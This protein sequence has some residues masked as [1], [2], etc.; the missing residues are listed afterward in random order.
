L[1]EPETTATHISYRSYDAEL[2]VRADG[3]ARLDHRDRTWTARLEPV[4]WPRLL[5][6]LGG[7]ETG[8]GTAARG[9]DV[10]PGGGPTLN[11]RGAALAILEALVHQLGEGEV[12]ADPAGLP[13]V[14]H[15]RATNEVRPPE[16]EA[17]AAFG[18]VAGRAACVILTPDEG[19]E[20]IAMPDG[21][22]LGRSAGSRLPTRAVALGRDL[23]ATGGDDRALRVWDAAAGGELYVR[24][25]PDGPVRAVAT[26]AG[27][28]VVFAAGRDGRLW[29]W[30]CATGLELGAIPGWEGSFNAACSARVAGLDLVAAGGDDGVVRVWNIADGTSV[31]TL[32]GHTG[33]VN[34]VAMLGAGDQGLVASAGLDQVV[35]IW[36]LGT[37]AEVRTLTGHTGSV[38]ALAFVEVA[39]GRPV[40]AS[41]S[42]DGT[43]RVWDV[44]KGEP[45]CTWQT[46]DGWPTA[47]ATVK[48]DG[49]TLL[50]TTALDGTV[51]LWDAATGAPLR[52][53]I[54]GQ[55]A[56][57]AGSVTNPAGSVTNPAG[58]AAAAGSVA[59]T[60]VAGRPVIA[61]GHQ[62]GTV[63]MWNAA[64][65]TPL[66]T[67]ANLAGGVTSVAFGRVG[68]VPV[69]VC[70]TDQGAVRL[71]DALTGALTRVPTPH[72]GMITALAFPPADGGGFL[73]SGGADLTVRTWDALTGRPLLCLSPGLA[74]VTAVAA[75]RALLAAAAPDGVVGVWDLE[76]RPQHAA[77]PHS[78]QVT[79]LA[80]G[81][82]EG[83]ELLASG[84]AQGT[85]RVWDPITGERLVT[86]SLDGEAVRALA[87]APGRLAVG[88]TDGTVRVVSLPGG[89]TLHEWTVAEPP[90]AVSFAGPDPDSVDV[91]GQSG[92][93]TLRPEGRAE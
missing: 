66:Y 92:V 31:H 47:L 35:R 62:D 93:R 43:V 30:D 32:S 75:G 69:L 52:T 91:A 6:A 33:W 56:S 48:A 44:G 38:T 13:W 34:A 67:L 29:A 21:E 72:T 81:T 51:S 87:L 42:L 86:L 68:G 57:P 28:D 76:G 88:H 1:L 7:L 11:P 80:F 22:S 58:S 73:V 9:L 8:A 74:G 60:T 39:A 63:R 2:T 49:R 45:L 37:G 17:A 89:V 50:A 36:D 90:L 55:P 78:S 20:L 82:V 79:A 16:Q 19:F 4:V 27:Q 24:Q 26:A 83:R 54:P 64:D 3:T 14:T 61:V 23:L 5:D 10:H 12:P 53:L 25:G 59:A 65:G 84:D 77:E 85:A 18:S 46:P 71:H 41:C 40:V 70:G 15:H